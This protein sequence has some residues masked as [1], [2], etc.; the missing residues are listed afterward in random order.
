MESA[1]ARLDNVNLTEE[2]APMVTEN[3]EMVTFTSHDRCDR[4]IAQALAV[5]RKDGHADLMFCWHHKEKH[6]DALLD[7]GWEVIEDYEAYESYKPQYARQVE[8][9]S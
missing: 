3:V 2:G 4:C 8:P 1:G 5:A 6:G 7:Q 9:V